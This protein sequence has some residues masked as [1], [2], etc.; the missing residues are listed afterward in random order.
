MNLTGDLSAEGL[1]DHALESIL[2]ANLIVHGARVIDIG[3][4]AGFPGLPIAIAR[5]DV[6]MSLLEPR[7]KRAAFLR[8]VVRD[9]QLPNARVIES[10]AEEVGGQTFDVATVRAVGGLASSLRESPF[11]RPG[12]TLLAW[13]TEPNALDGGFGRRFVFE[14]SL[15][16]P[17]SDQR[18]IAQ[19]RVH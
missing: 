2:G 7:A 13:T 19:Y 15:Q 5:R 9:L 6:Q 10:R 12:A 17:S 16:V 18:V 8:H 4:G 14:R 1:V 11:L 3:S